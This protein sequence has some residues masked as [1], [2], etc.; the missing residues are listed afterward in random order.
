[1]KTHDLV[2]VGNHGEWGGCD[3]RI[4]SNGTIIIEP[5]SMVQGQ[6]SGGKYSVPCPADLLALADREWRGLLDCD[7]QD[8]EAWLADFYPMQLWEL[9]CTTL[10][11]GGPVQ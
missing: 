11:R 4:R 7:E 1:M 10:R 2:T 6:S 5:Y 3:Y 8:C 9:P